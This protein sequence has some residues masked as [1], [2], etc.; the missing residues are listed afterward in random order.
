M[1]NERTGTAQTTGAAYDPAS[2]RGPNIGEPRLVTRICSALTVV[3][4]IG[5]FLLRSFAQQFDFSVANVLTLVMGFFTWLSLTIA[6]ATSRLPRW[7]W[8]AVA[9]TPLVVAALVLS[10]YRVVR[11]DGELVPQ[12]EPRWKI[13]RALPDQAQGESLTAAD[14]APRPTDFPQFLGPTRDGIVPNVE[15][16]TDWQAHPP[17]IHRNWCGSKRSEMDGPASRYKVTWALRSSSAEKNSGFPPTA[18][19]LASSSGIS[20]CRDTTSTRWAEQDRAVRQRFP[21][22]KC[23]LIWRQDR[24]CV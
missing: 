16:E 18:F 19:P 5:L 22:T 14:L 21:M 8:R 15:L 24:S 20:L 2:A 10:L 1:G 3:L 23:S 13:A 12:F 11:I 6:F 4:V 17:R 9:L 7:Y